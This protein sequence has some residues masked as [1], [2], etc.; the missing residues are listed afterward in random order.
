M[1]CPECGRG[2]KDDT[3]AIKVDDHGACWFCH[4]CHA[5]GMV[6]PDAIDDFLRGAVVV[7]GSTASTNTEL[8]AKRTFVG[9]LEISKECVAG[10][11]LL[12]RGC[13]L[14]PPRS[15]LR[16]LPQRR[17]LSGYSGPCLLALISDP[18][19][20][21]FVSVAQTWINADGSK[22]PVERPRLY[23]KGLPSRGVCRLWPDDVV[24]LGLGVPEGIETCL[25]LARIFIPV[26][27][28]MDAGGMAALPYLYPIESITVAV[29][30]DPS[31][32][33]AASELADRWRLAGAEV[34]EVRHHGS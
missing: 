9:A 20:N 7:S 33:K 22:A 12:A 10:Q 3:A 31:G 21:T 30:D 13:M 4:R 24:H 32:I 14:P 16:W 19:A 28:A 34:I 25:S 29:D 6:P 8:R 23:W 5:T 26:W 27:A 18:A 15:H 1:A 11:Y 17:H 2:P